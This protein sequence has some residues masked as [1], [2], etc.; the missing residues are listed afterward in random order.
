MSK[1]NSCIEMEI[2]NVK[3]VAKRPEVTELQRDIANLLIR[4]TPD[5]TNVLDALTAGCLYVANLVDQCLPERKRFREAFYAI[6]TLV[7]GLINGQYKDR[8]G[9]EV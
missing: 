1:D 4:A 8:E 6:S 7:V 2:I 3:A 5:D 9:D